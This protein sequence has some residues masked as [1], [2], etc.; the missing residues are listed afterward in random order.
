MRPVV[1]LMI[2]TMLAV[3]AATADHGCDAQAKVQHIFDAADT[4]SD[5]SLTP[6]EY[7]DAG[8]QQY[9]VSFDESDLNADGATTW[10]EYLE[11]FEAHHPSVGGDRV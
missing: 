3:P 8:L 6:A 9:G 10:A 2:T 11:L 5:G 1:L 7:E 4:N